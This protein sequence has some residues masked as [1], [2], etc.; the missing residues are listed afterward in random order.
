MK[1][2][3][4]QRGTEDLELRVSQRK[5]DIPII[6]VNEGNHIFTF[7]WNGVLFANS[8]IGQGSLR[9]PRFFFSYSQRI[10]EPL[11]TGNAGCWRPEKRSREVICQRLQ[12]PLGS[13]SPGKLLLFPL[14]LR[15]SSIFTKLKLKA[16]HTFAVQVIRKIREWSI[17]SV[18][19]FWK[20]PA[21][22]LSVGTV[23]L[24]LKYKSSCIVD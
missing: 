19:D 4:K 22:Q 10:V 23:F 11:T 15:Q 14:E 1:P 21:S 3:P 16:V 5:W 17:F 20:A 2:D 8:F 24:I 13:T 9:I 7:V 12:S 18:I 6:P